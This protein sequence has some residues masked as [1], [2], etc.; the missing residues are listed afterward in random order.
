[1]T[2]CYFSRGCDLAV[3]RIKR[4]QG[5][6]TLTELL[7]VAAIM[8]VLAGVA[9]PAVSSTC[10][11]LK[12]AEL[13]ACAREI[14]MAAQSRLL[15]LRFS[16][17]LLASGGTPLPEKPSDLG[18]TGLDWDAGAYVYVDQE[19]AD[20]IL[21]PG[22][23]DEQIR[24]G[25]YVVEYSQTTAMVYGVFY[26]EQEF[27]YPVA[28]RAADD[29]KE[30]LL[31]Y[32]GASG[33]AWG[34]VEQRE[35]PEFEIVNGDE[36]YLRLVPTGQTQYVVTVAD[37][38]HPDC[39]QQF[40]FRSDFYADPAADV[41]ENVTYELGEGSPFI[42]LLLDSLEPGRQLKDFFGG[43]F[44]PGVDLRITVE[45][46]DTG[47]SRRLPASASEVGNS[48]FAARVG[49]CAY[50]ACG[51]HLQNLSWTFSQADP[52]IQSAVQT[53][54]IVW[55][56][57]TWEKR[58][59]FQPIQG[60]LTSFDGKGNVIS[61]L[62]VRDESAQ[63][64][65]LF[66]SFQG[67]L[68]N[69]CLSGVSITGGP[70]LL[71]AGA[72]AG[73]L[74]D[75]DQTQVSEIKNCQVFA[76]P[77]APSASFLSAPAA[78]STCS[79]GGLVGIS[80]GA[81][82]QSC[83]ASLPLIS[84]GGTVGGLIGTA[85]DSTISRSYA[86]TGFWDSASGVWHAGITAGRAAGGLLGRAEGKTALQFCYAVGRLDAPSEG[87]LLTAG[88]GLVSVR[89]CYSAILCAESE[90]GTAP[91]LSGG[92][93]EN[94]FY[95]SSCPATSAAGVRAVT[96]DELCA[97]FQ[98]GPWARTAA[99]PYF[100][101]GDYPFPALEG[102]THYGDWPGRPEPSRALLA[103][104]ERYAH[105]EPAEYGYYA[106]PGEEGQT[107][108][109]TL[110]NTGAVLDD[111]YA[112][113]LPE[114]GQS[115]SSG[116]AA[117]YTSKGGDLKTVFFS[118]PDGRET[119][120]G[121]SYSVYRMA[122]ESEAMK[123][124][125]P[126]GAPWDYYCRLTIG[127]TAF[128][129]N[130]YF[131]KTAVNGALA[132]PGAPP[133][134]IEIRTARQLACL[135]RAVVR[136]GE[137]GHAFYQET[138]WGGERTYVQTRDIDFASYQVPLS[139]SPIGGSEGFEGR[140][141]GA[142]HLITG[143]GVS[144]AGLEAA[145]LFSRL[146]EGGAIE[147]TIFLSGGAG[148][149]RT[150]A[151]AACTG[152][153]VGINEGV[154]QNCSI[155]GFQ[156]QGGGDTG[157]FVGENR[158]LIF[159]CSASSGSF[160]GG[161]TGGSV[162][163]GQSTG[164]FVGRNCGSIR[165][166][167]ALAQLP[168]ASDPSSFPQNGFA[169]MNTGSITASYCAA[170][171]GACQYLPFSSAE[172]TSC[173]ALGY[174]AAK[175]ADDLA[176]LS[177]G[178]AW[179]MA[180]E[181]YPY[182]GSGE[183]PYPAVVERDGRKIHYGD[184]PVQAPAGTV[185]LAYYEQYI[186]GTYGYYAQV[187]D[188]AGLDTLQDTLP[189][190]ADGYVFLCPAGDR[191]APDLTAVYHHAGDGSGMFREVVLPAV[192]DGGPYWAY[193]MEPGSEIL[194]YAVPESESEGCCILQVEGKRYSF[195]P[196]FAKTGANGEEEADLTRAEIRTAR[197]LVCLSQTAA[198]W[199]EGNTYLQT[200]DIDFAS[201]VSLDLTLSPIGGSE[202]FY[203]VYDGLGHVISGTGI[204]APDQENAG[205]FSILRETGVV[206]NVLLTSGRGDGE[207]QAVLGSMYVG[208]LAGVNYGCIEN[209]AVAG[210]NISGG[211]YTGGLVGENW[212]AIARCAADNGSFSGAGALGGSICGDLYVGG[213]VG[214]NA[215]QIQD[216]YAVAR[217]S[218]ASGFLS[219]YQYGFA[220]LDGG[221]ITSC[222][223]ASLD[224]SGQFLP[225]S[226]ADPGSEG[227]WALGSGGI[228]PS[229]L[230]DFFVQAPWEPAGSAET[231]PYQSVGTYPY[232]AVVRR[233]GQTVHCGDW[234]DLNLEAEQN[235]LKKGRAE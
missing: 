207:A 235:G 128:Y 133:A 155:A 37:R 108:L 11:R 211:F 174:G 102:L 205:L 152:G 130:P 221:A 181:T 4:S 196:G 111:G 35:P 148:A 39:F 223:C 3:K 60:Y 231:Y 40:S 170:L 165:D 225:F 182:A 66:A 116:L 33:T 6:F 79:A 92:S 69:I 224:A 120:G 168:E 9:L 198:L 185:F 190:Q 203:A 175:T 150:I 62:E 172:Q 201:Y 73:V 194:S 110:Q 65:G 199:S 137:D 86:N 67:R 160:S 44:L 117:A 213:L 21:P 222:Y 126:D 13:D 45:A 177:L 29:R 187:P 109:D 122:P 127:E 34:P 154:I 23:I 26:A 140:Y 147:N 208:G 143:T 164:G 55:N 107:P 135:S 85:E 188:Q 139:L 43:T 22:T 162:A 8:T 230:S 97:C 145:G 98:G 157:G 18:E 219:F 125:T 114:D 100:C 14:F 77:H 233:D 212:G 206:Q 61:Q 171:D 112:F 46:S 226:D 166:C 25:Y 138:Y 141:N 113:L 200:R 54:D 15:D 49:N 178:S 132:V 156:I 176:D 215:G 217:I 184:W 197:Q 53:Q 68:E 234:P 209:C 76:V 24:A 91:F 48:L 51:R 93:A 64:L 10:T 158:G 159:Q 63:F 195:R 192:S 95:W 228:T 129:Y 163:G 134:E 189:V 161:E 121:M 57:Q 183:Y 118:E 82:I 17:I 59:N 83:S 204:Y 193:Y 94:C 101:E 210:F 87:A 149:A 104:Y 144:D 180:E 78:G 19:R 30:L 90:I 232:P 71:A 229:D 72:L 103:Y 47:D 96:W 106:V 89:S 41:P 123:Y 20:E 173:Y 105:Q 124:A 81:A 36:L 179:G 218:S 12:M 186:D 131:A 142:G 80:T 27:S 2:H 58:R 214:S 7:A 50:V 70:S 56:P 28:S 31:G 167:Y 146:K 227:R 151:G 32:Y 136:A 153:L 38:S 52:S 16:G 42:K 99:V 220:G 5:G 169:G 88:A 216:C 202:G 75:K 191:P 115:A 119:I 74:G 1:M 84:S